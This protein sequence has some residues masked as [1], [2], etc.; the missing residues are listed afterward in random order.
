MGDTPRR[1][2]CNAVNGEPQDEPETRL[3]MAAGLQIKLKHERKSEEI[4]EPTPE[5]IDAGLQLRRKSLAEFAA[6]SPERIEKAIVAA[7]DLKKFNDAYTT[8]SVTFDNGASSTE[9]TE[10]PRPKHMITVQEIN[11]TNRAAWKLAE[12]IRE[13]D[14]A[15]FEKSLAAAANAR[16]SARAAPGAAAMAVVGTTNREA[17]RTKALEYRRDHPDATR[18]G[19]AE[20]ISQSLNMAFTTV[21]DHLTALGLFASK[22]TKKK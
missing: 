13:S 20:G 3:R 4:H 5:E 11:K 8:A 22:S 15:D 18:D 17:V 6:P 19:T 10:Q 2:G 1:A 14:Q 12:E 9:E 21:K 7:I 16:D